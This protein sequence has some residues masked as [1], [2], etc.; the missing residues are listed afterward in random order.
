LNLKELARL[1]GVSYSTVSKALNNSHEISEPTKKRIQDLAKQHHYV[2]NA[3]VRSKLQ[4]TYNLALVFSRNLMFDGDAVLLGSMLQQLLMREIE[5]YG[6]TFTIN[7]SKNIDGESMVQRICNQGIVDGFIFVSD[8][9]EKEDLDYLKEINVPFV[10]CMMAPPDL[11]KD[12]SYFLTD[13]L[14]DGFICTEFLIKRGHRRIV[15]IANTE[16]H[17]DYQLRTEGYFRAMNL[18]GL[19]SKFIQFSMNPDKV[20]D[21]INENYATLSQADALFVQWDGVAG[22][23]MQYLIA[24]NVAIPHKLSILGY[25]DYPVTMFFRPMLTTMRDARELQCASAIRHLIAMINNPN[26]SVVHS[27]EC[28]EIILRE[29]VR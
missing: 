8:E 13:D 12:I 28:G 17:Y 10:F 25:N 20:E 22:V 18:H 3:K 1:A 15:T 23:V 19:D 29:S 16:K 2:H 7:A 27:R 11:P 6:Y 9:I 4:K 26:V 24:H 14:Q 21:L 5:Y